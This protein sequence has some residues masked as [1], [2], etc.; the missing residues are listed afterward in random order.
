MVGLKPSASPPSRGLT[1]QVSAHYL[2]PSI[3]I[4]LSPRT[5][6]LPPGVRVSTPCA[7]ASLGL[8]NL[9]SLTLHPWESAIFSGL[10]AAFAA[11][12]T[13]KPSYASSQ[14]NAVAAAR[15]ALD[16]V[17]GDVSSLSGSSKTTKELDSLQRM[18]IDPVAECSMIGVGSSIGTDLT[19]TPHV[20]PTMVGGPGASALAF[21]KVGETSKEQ[22]WRSSASQTDEGESTMGI[23]DLITAMA[24]DDE[25]QER[26]L[27]ALAAAK[28]SIQGQPSAPAV[29]T[30]KA[31]YADN[32]SHLLTLDTGTLR[33]PVTGQRRPRPR[34]VGSSESSR[35]GSEKLTPP[36]FAPSSFT[37]ATTDASPASTPRATKVAE[38]ESAPAANAG[39]ALQ[40]S[41][42]ST[43][44]IPP[45]PM[46]MFFSPSFHDL[47]SGKV[48]VWKGDLEIKG[49]GGGIFSVLIVG[50]EVTGYLW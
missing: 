18:N 23:D 13:T 44:C 14:I 5:D 26:Q 40:L 2:W 6:S 49:R 19:P 15:S 16:A 8:Q 38:V 24:E 17:L 7:Q 10:L 46:C 42:P 31:G 41:F 20:C 37:P 43:P 48:G 32:A 21:G 45:P 4:A 3:L 30:S 36:E 22:H 39:L 34:S 33:S 27:V 29:P 11:V 12:S 9:Y 50:E 47:H 25:E 1:L 35:E 28:F